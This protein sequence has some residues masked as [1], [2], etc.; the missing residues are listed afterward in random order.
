MLLKLLL[1]ENIGLKVYYGLEKLGFDV[2]GSGCSVW[3]RII[4]CKF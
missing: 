1:D 4:K 3:R 2:K